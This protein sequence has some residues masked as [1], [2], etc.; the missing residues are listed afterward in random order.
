M[1][2]YMAS[3]L[4]IEESDDKII[5]SRV[6]KIAEEELST[7]S[8]SALNNDSYRTALMNDSHAFSQLNPFYSCKIGYVLF[9]NLIYKLGVPLT[10]S[11][12]FSSLISFF[13]IC[14]ILFFI[15]IKVTNNVIL[16]GLITAFIATLSPMLNLAKLSSPDALSALFLILVA[17]FFFLK[18]HYVLLVLSMLLAISVRPDNIIFCSLLM[19]IE[20]VSEK[21]DKTVISKTI[22]GLI[23]IFVVYFG[24]MFFNKG[25][26]WNILFY[27]LF[28]EKQNIPIVS[29]HE[30]NL[31]IYFETIIH[32]LT[33]L[34]NPIFL[35]CMSAI[36]LYRIK[37]IQ[38]ISDLRNPNLPYSI[39]LFFVIW[40]TFFIRFFFYPTVYMRFYFVYFLIMVMA[41]SIDYKKLLSISNNTFKSVNV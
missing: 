17:G 31:K 10:Y 40:L 9:S 39:K 4:R 16:G 26:S 29:T 13:L 19:L 21:V 30:L 36:I 1:L 34:I 38:K 2:A 18:K 3:I 15:F 37:I 12:V 33:K 41:I 25:Q 5:H 32:H 20:P 27:N 14:I 7:E 23:S 35:F 6:Y 22:I 8:F 24:I 28:V 11:T